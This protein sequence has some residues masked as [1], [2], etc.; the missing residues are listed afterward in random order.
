MVNSWFVTFKPNR[1]ARVRLFCFPYAGSGVAIFR[2][3]VEL[4]PSY[5]ELCAVQL[6]GRESRL[7]EPLYTQL[8][9]LV[10]ACT[11]QLLPQLDLP[12]AFFG[13]SMGAL[14][15]FET[16]RQLR[17]LGAPMPVHLFVSGRRAPQ[18]P[19]PLPALSGLPTPSF[20]NELRLRYQGV[21]D[22]LVQDTELM[23][24]FLPIIKAD[25]QMVETYTCTDEPPLSMPLSCYGGLQDHTH[26]Q[27]DLDAWHLQ[28]QNT[29]RSERFE[30]GHFYFQ[31]NRLL[32][33]RVIGMELSVGSLG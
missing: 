32:L 23:Q 17:R 21:P 15:A 22:V 26:S 18:L 5:V 24:L 29:F 16:A 10:E 30:G 20:L 27:A 3:W 19:D 31:Q 2:Q 4:L 6:P 12:H 8:D 7:R 11:E 14:I 25:L 9:R 33:P 1:Q 28:T 13:H